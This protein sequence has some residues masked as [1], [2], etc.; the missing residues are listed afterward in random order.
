MKEHPIIMA[1]ES[2]P[3][4]LNGT[5][6]QTRR[7]I[8]DPRKNFTQYNKGLSMGDIQ[9]EA[10]INSKPNFPCPYGQVG[11][12]LWVKET[13][14]APIGYDALSP[15]G[16]WDMPKTWYFADG[17]PPK[18]F[19]IKR[20]SIF[21]PRWASRIELEIAKIRVE[22]IQDIKVWDCA[23][24]GIPIPEPFRFPSPR[25]EAKYVI[26]SFRELWDSLNSK[27]GHGWD[28]NPWVWSIEFKLLKG[29]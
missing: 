17:Q 6:T 28:K 9:R 8:K 21:M 14:A 18:N 16:L 20:P 25:E 7:V 2:V 12:R 19:G 11:D 1:S 3:N 24:E 26:C 22:R 5:K 29:G 4:I 15:S 13:W 23:N 10:E 27:R